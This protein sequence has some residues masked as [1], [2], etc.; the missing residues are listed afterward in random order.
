MGVTRRLF[1]VG[2]HCDRMR[3]L[4]N[5]NLVSHE[6]IIMRFCGVLFVIDCLPTLK[7][8]NSDVYACFSVHLEWNE[9]WDSYFSKKKKCFREPK[10]CGNGEKR[11]LS[12][13]WLRKSLRHLLMRSIHTRFIKT[14]R[15]VV[16]LF[17]FSVV[18][19]VLRFVIITTIM[20][21]LYD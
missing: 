14:Q 2:L 10:C 8:I 16:F 6:S 21:D 4:G 7:F 12:Q 19:V 1:Q 13:F 3:D 17:L 11:V 15:M 20:L 18:I 5:K 9:L